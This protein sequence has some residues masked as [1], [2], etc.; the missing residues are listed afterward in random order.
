MK[1]AVIGSIRA[2]GKSKNIQ[3]N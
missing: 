3:I 2:F 1:T